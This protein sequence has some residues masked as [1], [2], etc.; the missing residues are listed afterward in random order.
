MLGTA[1]LYPIKS[2]IAANV[3]NGILFNKK[4]MV[5]AQ[6]NKSRP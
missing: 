5:K 6:T 1:N 2:K 3:A 4:G